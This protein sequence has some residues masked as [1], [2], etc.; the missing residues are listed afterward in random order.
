MV[1]ERGGATV[2]LGWNVAPGARYM[3]NVQ[4]FDGNSG[5]LGSTKV[6]VDNR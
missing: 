3:G 6:L 5:S 2:S 4:F 1:Y